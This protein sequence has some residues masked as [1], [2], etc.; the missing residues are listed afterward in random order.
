MRVLAHLVAV[1]SGLKS[2]RSDVIIRRDQSLAC[3][4]DWLDI[5]LYRES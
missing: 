5:H 2:R 1:D 4:F 3:D